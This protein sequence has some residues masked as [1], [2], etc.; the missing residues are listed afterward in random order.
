MT[1]TT[2]I[3]L[4][5][6]AVLVLAVS[7]FMAAQTADTQQQQVQPA[8]PQYQPLDQPPPGYQPDP[9]QNQPQYQQQQQYQDQSQGPPPLT[10]ATGTVIT[11]RIDQALS[12][13]R[14][15]PG[16]TFSATL[17][18]P[19]VA[20][21]IVVAQRGQTVV[22]RVIDVQKAKGFSGNSSLQLALTR[23]TL[24]DGQSVP[25][26]TELI[27]NR[28]KSSTG[29]DVGA[30]GATTATGAI[31]G[32]AAGRGEGAGIG[33]G[34]GAAAGIIGVLATKGYATVVYPESLLTFQTTITVPI[35]TAN[36]PQAF[37]AVDPSVYE[38][39]AQ[40]QLEPPPQRAA[41]EYD[42]QPVVAAA[43][44]PVVLTTAAP[45]VY[46][47]YPYSV[48]GPCDPFW[49]P[50][51]YGPTVSIWFGGGYHRP[52][53][54]EYYGVRYSPYRHYY[55]PAYYGGPRYYGPRY[56]SPRYVGPRYSGRYASAPPMRPYREP[57]ARA[58]YHR[59]S[60]AP[61]GGGGDRGGGNRGGGGDH[62]GGG[63][64]RGSHR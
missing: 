48:Y 47:P 8:Q 25:I 12:S 53:F 32:A 35:N 23:L 63:H 31:I 16:D 51:C 3:R 28:G 46:Y 33:A 61:R 44:Q 18:Q 24:V 52:W 54:R 37:H 20:Q 64:D 14:N 27:V 42:Q 56:V 5:L 50:Y 10:V 2:A 43:P 39:N 41:V 17:T 38:R 6:I 45:V 4:F 34:V 60:A 21:G 62:G 55:A 29:R 7:G 57:V 11:V 15:R 36:A 59:E 40:P 26:H 22:G 58:S 9:N 1:R 49:Y 30:V 13:D 19:I